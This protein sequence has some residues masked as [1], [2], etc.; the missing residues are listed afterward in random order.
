MWVCGSARSTRRTLK[1]MVGSVPVLRVRFRAEEAST[2][3]IVLAGP[4][5]PARS[6]VDGVVV[7][8]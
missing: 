8:D 3:A 4:G 2:E 6:P 5:V 7:G 1:A